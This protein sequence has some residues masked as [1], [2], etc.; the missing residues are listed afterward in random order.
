[1]TRYF[2]VILLLF[3]CLDA[4][5]QKKGGALSKIAASRNT[6]PHFSMDVTVQVYETA[7]DKKG[8]LLGKGLIRKSGTQYYSS[9]QDNEMIINNDCTV[10]I[11]HAEKEVHYFADAVK[12]R[13][14]EVAP[15]LDLEALMKTAD[16][17]AS[18]GNTNG[19][20][21]YTIF[22]KTGPI[23]Q[24]E[25]YADQQT[26]LIRKIVYFYNESDRENDYGIYKAV[27]DYSNISYNKPSPDFFSE[28]KYIHYKERHP[29]LIAGYSKY[30]L[31]ID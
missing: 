22:S 26:Y 28:K 3:L 2:P 9:F 15:F 25:V 17:V 6:V 11:D 12:A 1:M 4:T 5:A 27:I 29:Q 19:Q 8:T 10:L 30:K 21:H 13:Q 18:H 20:M 7:S 31:F 24:T 16:S 14:K 23:R